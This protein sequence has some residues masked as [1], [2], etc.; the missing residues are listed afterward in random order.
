M[1]ILLIFALLTWFCCPLLA[2]MPR[3]Q[4]AL[5]CVDAKG[6]A[7]FV[8]NIDGSLEFNQKLFAQAEAKHQTDKAQ[9]EI[10][11]KSAHDDNERNRIDYE[12]QVSDA[13]AKY[14]REWLEDNP[15]EIRKNRI[16]SY[17]REIGG[18]MVGIIAFAASGATLWNYIQTWSDITVIIYGAMG[19]SVLAV[20]AGYLAWRVYQQIIPEVNEV[21]PPPFPGLG[22]FPAEIGY[23]AIDRKPESSEPRFQMFM[24]SSSV[25]V[26]GECT[27]DR[28]LMAQDPKD[29]SLY[30]VRRKR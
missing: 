24:P 10:W 25:D 29:K 16:A 19:S 27:E 11:A 12:R 8:R 28:V 21:T 9:Q 4:M 6:D 17:S 1:R 5:V 22:W 13:K 3:A 30:T 18:G 20:V 2:K 26:T 14:E 15:E 7:R 23:P